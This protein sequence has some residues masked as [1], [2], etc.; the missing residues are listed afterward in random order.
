MLNITL[1]KIST[2]TVKTFEIA[3]Q[4]ESSEKVRL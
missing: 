2:Y 3:K 1:A 4:R